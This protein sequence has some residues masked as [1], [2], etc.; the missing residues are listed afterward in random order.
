MKVKRTYNK[1]ELARLA[2][3]SYTTFYRWMVQ[4][5]EE[6]RN[7]GAA[8]CAQT[9]HGKALALVCEEFNIDLS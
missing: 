2:G 5:Q 3:V 8:P 6:L 1:R 9:L 4:H 7:M